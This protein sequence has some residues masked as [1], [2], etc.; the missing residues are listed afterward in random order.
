LGSVLRLLI[1]G[2]RYACNNPATEAVV[3]GGRCPHDAH[4]VDELNR[5]DAG[6]SGCIHCAAIGVTESLQEFHWCLWNA[7]VFVV[8][9]VGKTLEE[10]DGRVGV[11]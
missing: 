5:M 9:D 10:G 1:Y 8:E 2:S 4:R 3:I 7:P 11:E 6:E